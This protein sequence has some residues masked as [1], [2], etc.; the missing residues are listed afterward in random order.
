[1]VEISQAQRTLAEI[2]RL[3]ATG[4]RR[5]ASVWYPLLL[6]AVVFL[7]GAM[8]AVTVHRNHLGPYFAIGLLAVVVLSRRHYRRRDE[9]DGLFIDRKLLA[10]AAAL[11]LL[12]G[13][14]VSHLGFLVD[15][16]LIDTVGPL[17]VIASFFLVFAAAS[18]NVVLA[19]VGI[20]CLCATLAVVPLATGDDR[21]AT[22]EVAYA[23][24][25]AAAGLAQ[26]RRERAA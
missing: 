20:A 24:I 9:A 1:M 10:T 12:A 16:G 19:A 15:S 23:L 21:V 4:R 8:A 13:A 5:Q 2:G 17:L 6:L 11:T 26:L 18:R 25:L 7:G 22:T 3:G 14:A